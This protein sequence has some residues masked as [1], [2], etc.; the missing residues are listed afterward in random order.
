LRGSVRI[1][2]HVGRYG[3]EEF[4]AILPE[5][6]AEDARLLA[7]RL[8]R[9]VAETPFEATPDRTIQR[10]VSIGV[11]AYPEDA[12]D[13]EALVR[14]ADDALYRAKRAGKNRAFTA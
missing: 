12:A 13:P 7:E 5:T 2:D 14:L 6:N 3:G 10:T 11:A 4:L 1:S 8:C 9:T